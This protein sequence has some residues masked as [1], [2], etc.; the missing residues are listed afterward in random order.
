MHFEKRGKSLLIRFSHDGKPYSFSLP[1]H[2]NPVGISAAKGKIAQ[3]EKDILSGHFDTTLLKY[4][5]RKLG[6][7]PTAISA[8][9][10]FEKYIPHH[11]QERGLS[12]GSVLRLE[13]IASKLKQLLGDKPAEKVTESVAKDAIARWSES[14]SSHTIK[15]YLYFLK[16]CWDWAQGRYHTAETNPWDECLTRARLRGNSE[17]PRQQKKPFTTVELRSILAAFSVHPHYSH[18][19]QFVTFLASTACR[20]GEVA[21]LRWKHI[22]PGFSTAWI[23]ESISRGHQNKKGTKTGKSRIIQLPPSVRV[24]LAE[25]FERVSP[26]PDDLIFP[27]PKGLAIDD[28]RFRARAWKTILASCQIEYRTPYNLR[29]SAI[30]HALHQGVSPIAL[31]EQTGHDKRVMLSTYAHAIDRECLFIDFGI[32]AKR[33]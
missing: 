30:S 12:R 1:K 11:Q 15:T 20:F 28:H 24:M 10:L 14:A 7:N 9:E 29:H 16:S 13:A 3:I 6:K 32:Q 23:G 8:V 21:G 19:T 22:D 2:N 31:A 5:P 18:Y 33:D 26:Q 27:S 25:R 17:Y 4:K